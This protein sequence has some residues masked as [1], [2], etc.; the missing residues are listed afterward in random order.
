[1]MIRSTILALV[2][3]LSSISAANA[4]K[5]KSFQSFV[6]SMQKDAIA[7]GVSKK[8]FERATKGLKPDPQIDKL[9]RKQPE[10]VKPIGGYIESRISGYLVK[11]GR[12]KVRNLKQTLAK[13]E[14]AY[15]VDP[16]VVAAIWGM[17]TG[18]G[19]GIGTSNAFRAL[20]T[21]AWKR[22]RKDFFRKEFLQALLIMQEEGLNS[23]QMVSSWAGAMGQTQFIPSSFRKFA[24]DFNKD[25]KRDL[26]KTKGDA[27]ASTANYLKQKG[28]VR[29]QPWGF[30]VSIPK[31][32]PRNAKTQ[33]WNK[34]TKA[35]V[36]A[37]SSKRFPKKG[38]ATLFFPAGEE[39][40]AFLISPN[41]EVIRDYNSADSYSLSVGM[42]A[43]RLRGGKLLKSSW[44]K[45]KTLNKAQR[46]MKVQSLLAKKGYKVPNRTGRIIKGVRTAIRDFQ[47]KIGVTADG[48]PDLGLLKQLGG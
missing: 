20:A 26:W 10:L 40:P 13:L 23:K 21:L 47:V 5:N 12:G 29:G 36:K 2:M 24:V 34:W 19:R 8:T 41:Y 32:L 38:V 48:Y 22:Y 42:V 11:S 35:G 7:L 16:Y 15:G 9:T 28:W 18:Y 17:E 27:L 25:G 37:R 43:N 39:G 46:S 4:A 30:P 14:K 45:I 44:P 1:M 6:K 33:S 31:N 3:G